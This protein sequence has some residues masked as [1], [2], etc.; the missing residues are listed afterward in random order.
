MYIYEQVNK[1]VYIIYANEYL[2]YYIYRSIEL[3]LT[4]QIR[5]MYTQICLYI[6]K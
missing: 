6:Y 4:A 2:F 1:D 5:G 3:T